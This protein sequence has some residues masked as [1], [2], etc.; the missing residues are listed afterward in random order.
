[1]VRSDT[2]ALKSNA[3]CGQRKIGDAVLGEVRA[4]PKPMAPAGDRSRLLRRCNEVARLVHMRC[5]NG[6]I[7][8]H[9]DAALVFVDA[10]TAANR[11]N[12]DWSKCAGRA[13]ADI[14]ELGESVISEAID[15]TVKLVDRK[16]QNYRPMTT[17][18]AGRLLALQSD[19]RRELEIVTMYPADATKEQV[20]EAQVAT[21]RKRE[22]ERQRVKRSLKCTPRAEWLADAQEKRRRWEAEGVSRATWYRRQRARETDPLLTDCVAV[23]VTRPTDLSHAVSPHI[24]TD[25]HSLD[26]ATVAS[27]AHVQAGGTPPAGDD[28]EGRVRHAAVR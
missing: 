5:A 3:I 15:R 14:P 22:R 9:L 12:R 4:A 19:E 2:G 6:V 24:E 25:F 13:L 17:E 26:E 10:W 18:V 20:R 28:N 27:N 1:M 16:G 7:F 21:K 23:S 8:D 11:Q